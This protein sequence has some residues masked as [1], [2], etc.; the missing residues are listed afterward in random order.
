MNIYK[1]GYT[2]NIEKHSPT[3][4]D[5]QLIERGWLVV[6]IININVNKI[7]NDEKLNDIKYNI[8]EIIKKEYDN[9][10]KKSIIWYNIKY[11]KCKYTS[12]ITNEIK[13]LLKLNNI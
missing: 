6:N 2:Y 10:I 11:L 5:K 3:E 1:N 9:A 13:E 7:I 4:T 8:D 12:E